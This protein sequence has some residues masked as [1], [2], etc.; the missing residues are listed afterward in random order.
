MTEVLVLALAGVSVALVAWLL[1]RADGRVVPTD[2]SIE[3][4][5]LERLGIPPGASALVEFTAPGCRTC[6]AA[7][8][9]L[10]DVAAGYDGVRV[11]SAD[12]GAYLELAR[13]HGIMRAPTTLV[14]DPGGRVR[15]RVH[16]VPDA[17]S[18]HALLRAGTC[19]AA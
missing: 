2:A 18:L 10:D 7:R 6:V 8:A 12:A 17:G 3:R 1:R 19:R 11:V 13:E 4:A 9:V 15:H 14:V 16:G 5:A